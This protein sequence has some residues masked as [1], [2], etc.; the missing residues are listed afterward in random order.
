MNFKKCP[1]CGNSERGWGKKTCGSMECVREWKSWG[2]ELR[3]KAMIMAELDPAQRAQYML[4]H[5]IVNRD[6]PFETVEVAEPEDRVLETKV[7]AMPESLARLLA[8]PA[9]PISESP[10]LSEEEQRELRK[11]QMSEVL[12][13]ET[14][15]V[16][17]ELDKVGLII[18]FDPEKHQ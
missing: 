13:Q 18:P 6:T 14:E 15:P 17:V 5:G 7:G 11:K 8:T 4:E 16:S 9:T 12:L 10:P 3:K 1:V 2:P